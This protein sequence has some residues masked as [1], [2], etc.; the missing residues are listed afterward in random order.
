LKIIRKT[1]SFGQEHNENLK[2]DDGKIS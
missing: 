1:V 2:N